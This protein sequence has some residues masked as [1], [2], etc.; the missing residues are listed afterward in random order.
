VHFINHQ[1]VPLKILKENSPRPISDGEVFPSF[2]AVCFSF[3]KARV[4]SNGNLY[5][6]ILLYHLFYI[7]KQKT[8]RQKQGGFNH[9]A[10]AALC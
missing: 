4:L 1:L 7:R 5:E 2:F 8:E 10:I 9:S 6:K 3:V